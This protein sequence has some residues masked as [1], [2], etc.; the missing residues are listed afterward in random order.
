MRTTDAVLQQLH[1]QLALLFC[2]VLYWS[3]KRWLRQP[4]V[5]PVPHFFFSSRRRHTRLVSDW[6]SDVCSSDL[7]AS[8]QVLECQYGEHNEGSTREPGKTPAFSLGGLALFGRPP[9]SRGRDI[10]RRPRS[11]ERRVGKECR[12]RWSPYH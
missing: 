2:V 3:F 9:R 8:S 11:E 10:G 7:P 4:A 12:S 1:P 5:S 6:S